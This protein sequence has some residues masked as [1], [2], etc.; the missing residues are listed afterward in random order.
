MH[1]VTLQ[2]GD[3]HELGR[4]AARVREAVFVR[5][6]GIAAPMVSDEADF[7]AVH[8]VAYRDGDAIGAARL[9]PD[10]AIGRL[11]VLPHARRMGVGSLILDALL[12]QAARRRYDCVRLYAQRDAVPFYL[13]HRFSTV[14]EPF[15]EAGVEHV[16]MLRRL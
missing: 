3:W 14:G 8:V 4:D 10:G 15:Y 1:D 5:E 2:A 7:D 9:L 16:E 11:A 12:D 6:L 13:R